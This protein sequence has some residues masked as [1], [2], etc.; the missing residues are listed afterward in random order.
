M[1]IIAD[2]N[3]EKLNLHLSHKRVELCVCLLRMHEAIRLELWL[4]GPCMPPEIE[5]TRGAR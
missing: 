3:R 5:N 1:H 4:S 2:R